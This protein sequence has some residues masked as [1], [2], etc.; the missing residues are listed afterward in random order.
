VGH[1]LWWSD[2]RSSASLL[3]HRANFLKNVG[4][5]EAS[6]KVGFVD[7]VGVDVDC[8]EQESIE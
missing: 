5:S 7:L 2:L 6:H 1:P 4:F 8:T 3:R